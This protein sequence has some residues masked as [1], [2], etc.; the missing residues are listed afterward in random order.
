MGNKSLTDHHNDGER[1][2]A[3]GKDYSEP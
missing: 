2:R 1:D 3:S